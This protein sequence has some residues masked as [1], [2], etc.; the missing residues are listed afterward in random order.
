MA[1]SPKVLFSTLIILHEKKR[2]KISNR[3]ILRRTCFFTESTPEKCYDVS[4]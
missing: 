1:I 4:T 2:I 3:M